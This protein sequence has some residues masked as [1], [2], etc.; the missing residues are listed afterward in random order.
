MRVLGWL[1][2]KAWLKS[3]DQ[4]EFQSYVASSVSEKM[5]GNI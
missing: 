4:K 1:V 5:L 3:K 2:V